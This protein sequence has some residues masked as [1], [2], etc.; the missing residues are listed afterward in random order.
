MTRVLKEA[1]AALKKLDE[2]R[3][4]TEDDAQCVFMQSLKLDE[5]SGAKA[6]ADDIAAMQDQ[7]YLDEL[8]SVQAAHHRAQEHDVQQLHDLRVSLNDY[9]SPGDR[10]KELY[11]LYAARRHQSAKL[12]H[13]LQK[14]DV[15]LLF[16]ARASGGAKGGD[17]RDSVVASMRNSIRKLRDKKHLSQEEVDELMALEGQLR[18]VRHL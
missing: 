11:R 3:K 14:A 16:G 12:E 13:S 9:A 6:T 15:P 2:E 4:A 17:N 18:A 5:L 8:R 7:A 1:L 10:W